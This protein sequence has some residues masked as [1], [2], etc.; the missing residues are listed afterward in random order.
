VLGH[1]EEETLL[2]ARVVVETQGATHV[3]S[4][5]QGFA[6]WELLYA[7]SVAS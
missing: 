1:K 4:L 2:L 5:M 3:G 7:S 6:K